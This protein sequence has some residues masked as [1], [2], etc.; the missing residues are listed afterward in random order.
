[1]S[2]TPSATDEVDLAG[3]TLRTAGPQDAERM[4]DV[5][6]EAFTARPPVDP[7]A[8]FLQD[9]IETVA[10]R[11]AATPGV[12]AE[13]NGPD[14]P[15][16]VGC[17]LVSL[18]VFGDEP[19]QIAGLHR[20]SVRP[21]YRNSGVAE[22]I[23]RAAAELASDLG[24][25]SVR[26]LCRREFP[27]TRAWWERHG[28][29]VVDEAPT[30]Q[31]MGRL[32]PVRGEAPDADAM[33]AIGEQLAG[34]L[35][36]GDIVIAS[37]DLGAGKTTLAQGLGRGLGVT[38]P[39]ISPTFVLSRIHQ[40]HTGRPGL[41]HVDAYRIGSALELDDL[42][43]ESSL[44]GSSGTGAVAF[45]EWG[46]GLAEG[47]AAD[48]LELD[49]RRSDDPED[50]TR[51]VFLAGVGARWDGVDLAGVLRAGPDPTHEVTHEETHK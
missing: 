50:E 2:S 10:N 34:V 41:V 20:V 19:G 25:T 46:A 16:M 39:V 49:I 21:A 13:L 17:L 28:F 36:P 45:I 37:G 38:D 12:V 3:L 43:L 23:V 6:R 18:D 48:R 7:P 15:T 5:I 8:D 47:L 4:L 11:L 35:E 32:L 42:D 51:E 31:I 9:S 29:R 26:L 40:S 30:G 33:R 22:V 14:G 27:E 1:M 44:T 24:A